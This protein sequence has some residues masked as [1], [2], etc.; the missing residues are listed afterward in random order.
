MKLTPAN[1]TLCSVSRLSRSDFVESSLLGKS[2]RSVP[3]ERLPRIALLVDNGPPHAVTGL[4]AAYNDFLAHAADD[5]FL[6]F[7]HD[8]VFVHDWFLLERLTEAFARFDVV[9]VAGNTAPDMAQP[10]WALK[11]NADLSPAG[12]QDRSTM[13]GAVGHGDPTAPP[14]SFYGSTPA[15]CELLDGVFLGV[16]VKR[17][18][19]AK[20]TFDTR[21]S[22][23]C[24]DLDF[25]R[26]AR[27]AGLKVGTWPLALTHASVGNFAS[28]AWKQE[29][30]VYLEKWR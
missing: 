21:F 12:W 19:Q 13:S 1:T 26:T 28:Q 18:R 4:A 8:D 10:S 6:L 25:C 11:F 17:L 29:A 22:F 15:A 27:N 23:H 7:V 16:N 3:R 20:V 9:G 5:D 14:V 2:L 30:A 24:Y